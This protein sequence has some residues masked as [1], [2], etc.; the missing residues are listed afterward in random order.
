MAL[1]FGTVSEAVEVSSVGRSSPCQHPAEFVAELAQ[2]ALEH[3]AV[4]HPYLDALRDGT[5]PDPTWALRD[6]ANQYIGYSKAFPDYLRAVI[7]QLPDPAHQAALQDNL[8]EESGQYS[9]ED[10]RELESIGVQR[11]W[12]DGVP[13]PDLFRRFVFAVGASAKGP[14]ENMVASW[15]AQLL[16]ILSG[17]SAAKAVGAIGLGTENVVSTMY[18]SFVVACGREANLDGRST[19]F[20]ALHTAIDDDHQETLQRLA[21]DFATTARGR[22]DLRCGMLEALSARAAFWDW[23]LDRA[24]DSRL[25]S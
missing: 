24:L 16:K 6:F 21:E 12:V 15:R 4:R 1:E 25:H 11:E 3:R 19:V 18:Q 10:L 13:H 14:E 2:L 17:G 9:E 20:F 23:M 7:A 5:L 8:T 22:S